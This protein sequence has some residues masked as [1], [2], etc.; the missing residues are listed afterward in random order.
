MDKDKIVD[1]RFRFLRSPGRHRKITPSGFLLHLSDS[2]FPPL[3]AHLGN[4][5]KRYYTWSR[6]EKC[7]S[8]CGA[9]VPGLDFPLGET[10]GRR[11]RARFRFLR[12]SQN[13]SL[14]APCYARRDLGAARNS[15][16]STICLYR[17]TR[18]PFC[19]NRFFG[20]VKMF[21]FR[22]RVRKI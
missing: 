9:P 20:N 15:P 21:P 11:F 12:F 7:R 17:S 5:T 18:F 19:K 22:T 6:C 1:P 14:E 10:Q 13:V 8:G 16:K 4:S 3:F 2:H